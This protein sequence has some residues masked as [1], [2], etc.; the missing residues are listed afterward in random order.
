MSALWDRISPDTQQELAT[1]RGFLTFHLSSFSLSQLPYLTCER[2]PDLSGQLKLRPGAVLRHSFA[3]STSAFLNI[4]P[5]ACS[6]RIV[7]G[8]PDTGFLIG[9]SAI[10][11]S[12]PARTLLFRP[13]LL[14]WK[15]TY[16]GSNNFVRITGKISN[17][18]PPALPSPICFKASRW[19]ALAFLS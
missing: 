4:K 2:N 12:S 6:T 9:S 15:S 17:G 7:S 19:A 1:P 3:E 13:L 14:Y 5:V 8:L 11:T 10:C 16:C 18:R